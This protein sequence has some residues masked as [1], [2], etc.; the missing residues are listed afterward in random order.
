M[1]AAESATIVC[2]GNR[3][4]PRDSLGAEVYDE[5]RHRTLP[6]GLTV[7]DGG[8]GSIDLLVHLEGPATVVVVDVI[9]GTVPSGSVCCLHA[10]E[11]ARDGVR[12]GH[13]AGAE[14]LIAVAPVILGGT[15]ADVWL[16]GTDRWNPQT[17]TSI[18]DTAVATATDR[19]HRRRWS[20]RQ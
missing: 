18:A 2:I 15:R 20:I 3:L 9:E 4:V 7:V 12:F 14:Y 16:V 8:L 11:L 10:D 1:P 5:L 17:V 13:G 19:T 6:S